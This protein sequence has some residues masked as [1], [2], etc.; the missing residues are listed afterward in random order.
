M[1]DVYTILVSLKVAIFLSVLGIAMMELIMNKK[2]ASIFGLILMSATFLTMGL[3]ELLFLISQR[4]QF[5][6]NVNIVFMNTIFLIVG[7]LG[8]ILYFSNL[9]SKKK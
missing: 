4:G 5:V 6:F 2:K 7:G 3:S 9:I 1:D 8:L